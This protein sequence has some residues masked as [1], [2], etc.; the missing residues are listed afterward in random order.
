M[1]PQSLET[2]INVLQD[3]LKDLPENLNSLDVELEFSAKH[4]PAYDK[5]LKSHI[6]QLAEVLQSDNHAHQSINTVNL[7]HPVKQ[8]I[9]IFELLE[10]D[11]IQ[12]FDELSQV[13][14]AWQ[15]ETAQVHA[16][17]NISEAAAGEL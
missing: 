9:Q 14:R 5:I 10:E 8:L 2:Q 16:E 3:H 12:I 6:T 15:S 7:A 1:N 13:V 4:I 11:D 17:Q